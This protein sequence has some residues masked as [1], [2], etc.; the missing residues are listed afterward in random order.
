MSRHRPRRPP[1]ATQRALTPAV[2]A[3]I[4]ALRAELNDR[5]DRLHDIVAAKRAAVASC[6]APIPTA[7]PE[8]PAGP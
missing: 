3:R 7:N 8:G 5:L 4:L 1:T 6:S 2:Q